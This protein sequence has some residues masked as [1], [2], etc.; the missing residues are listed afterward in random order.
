MGGG[1]LTDKCVELLEL[2]CASCTAPS[3]SVT[4]VD[5][6]AVLCVTPDKAHGS[7]WALQYKIGLAHLW[8]CRLLSL[9]RRQSDR[10]ALRG[11]MTDV[12]SHGQ[13]AD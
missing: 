11:L 1:A 7:V 9:W 3:S 10:H 8:L 5:S 13:D 12:V 4:A 6:T 2:V